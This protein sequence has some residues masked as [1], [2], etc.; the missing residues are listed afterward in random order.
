VI[1][2]IPTCCSSQLHSE[3]HCLGETTLEVGKR[4]ADDTY[5]VVMKKSKNFEQ[6]GIQKYR[7]FEFRKWM[8]DDEESYIRCDCFPDELTTEAFEHHVK[9]N[10]ACLCSKNWGC[11]GNFDWCL[12]HSSTR[13]VV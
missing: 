7:H 8:S 4:K 5:D 1:G 6:K 12:L 10:P 9:G 13:F 2:R 11:H 3:Y